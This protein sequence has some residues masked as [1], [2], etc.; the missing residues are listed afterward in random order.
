[1]PVSWLVIIIIKKYN[2]YSQNPPWQIIKY[3]DSGMPGE[4]KG[5]VIDILNSLSKKLN[6]TYTMHIIPVTYFKGNESEILSYNVSILY[7]QILPPI[8][9]M[10]LN[11]F[12]VQG[13]DEEQLPTFNIPS[14]IINVVGQDKVLFAAVGATI[15]EKYLRLINFTIPISIQPY[16]FIV[17][18]VSTIPKESTR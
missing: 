13:T 17:S 1:M 15:S 8:I 10:N 12:L 7:I 16:N 4:I 6:F 2:I 14:E 9:K 5:V 11:L 3:N 18:R